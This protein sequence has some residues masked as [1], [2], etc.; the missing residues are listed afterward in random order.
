MAVLD[1]KLQ[2]NSRGVRAVDTLPADADRAQSA[3]LDD[4]RRWVQSEAVDRAPLSPKQSQVRKPAR[5]G[6]RGQ[7]LKAT[8]GRR[9]VPGTLERSIDSVKRSKDEAVVF[10]DQSSAAYAGVIHDR[11]YETWQDLGPGSEAKA[12][13]LGV[14][15]GEKFLD[16]AWDE[17][18]DEIPRRAEAAWDA[19]MRRA[20]DKHR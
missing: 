10:T 9:N 6:A 13:R 5:R 11:R 1:F 4:V 2:F 16:R 12:Q 17:N 20:S 7:R 3:M 8:R 14:R 18:G 15:V 19:A